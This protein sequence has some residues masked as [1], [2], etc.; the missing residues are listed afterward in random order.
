MSFVRIVFDIVP[1]F[2]RR[3]KMTE[4]KYDSCQKKIHQDF[5]SFVGLVAALAPGMEWCGTALWWGW[6]LPLHF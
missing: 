3:L 5:S 1:V 6:F 4:E 2:L